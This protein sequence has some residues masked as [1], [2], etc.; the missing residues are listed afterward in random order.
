MRI[1]TNMCYRIKPLFSAVNDDEVEEILAQDFVH[2]IKD[3]MI[4]KT[5][6]ESNSGNTKYIAT[7]YIADY[8]DAETN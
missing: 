4:I 1:T 5:E 6:L 3:H 8:E 2:V 7:L